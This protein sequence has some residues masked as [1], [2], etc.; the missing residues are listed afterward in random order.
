MRAGIDDLL[1]RPEGRTLDFKRHEAPLPTWNDL[2]LVLR[3][4]LHPHPEV[5]VNISGAVI[6]GS[7]SAKG[8]VTTNVP[9]NVTINER[10][11]WFIEQIAQEER[12]T[13]ADLAKAF[14]VS[15]RTAKRDLAALQEAGIIQFIGSRKAG[16]YEIA[17]Q[18]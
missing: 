18:P 4:A 5:Q 3:V 9:E 8:D 7:P 17:K 2:G 16:R 13:S 12:V 6:E 10:Q 15:I 14:G 11:R 1:T